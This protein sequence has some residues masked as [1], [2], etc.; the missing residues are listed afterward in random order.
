MIWSHTIIH[1]QPTLAHSH[2]SLHRHRRPPRP[3]VCA[4]TKRFLS[5]QFRW[6][7]SRISAKMVRSID[8]WHFCTRTLPRPYAINLETEI[9]SGEKWNWRERERETNERKTMK[10]TCLRRSDDICQ[11]LCRF[12]ST[13]R[14]IFFYFIR[15]HFIR[16][17]NFLISHSTF[18]LI[19]PLVI[20][21]IIC[22][23]LLGCAA[24]AAATC[25]H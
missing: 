24:A 1:R 13:D 4:N 7:C 20:I 19:F 14:S 9:D 15:A 11:L 25:R 18:R 16:S 17:R 3:H 6:K 5:L 8:M 21:F 12:T 23:C 2:T 10:R 22:V